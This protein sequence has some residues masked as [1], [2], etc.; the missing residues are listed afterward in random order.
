MEFVLTYIRDLQYR[1]QISSH[2]SIGGKATEIPSCPCY[3]IFCT[4]VLGLPSDSWAIT[5]SEAAFKNLILHDLDA[6]MYYFDTNT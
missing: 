6:M 4:S 3:H 5:R 1:T 2:T